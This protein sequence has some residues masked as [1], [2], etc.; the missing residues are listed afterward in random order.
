MGLKGE[1]PSGA[2]FHH[3]SQKEVCSAKTEEISFQAFTWLF[4]GTFCFGTIGNY[5]LINKFPS[6]SI[7]LSSRSNIISV[8]CSKSLIWFVPTIVWLSAASFAQHYTLVLK[9]CVT[10]HN[11]I[12]FYWLL[13]WWRDVIYLYWL[14]IWSNSFVCWAV[15]RDQWPDTKNRNHQCK[16]NPLPNFLIVITYLL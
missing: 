13:I 2:I 4:K 11:V 14:L 8:G 3:H 6:I 5:T 7:S 9:I 1:I 12:Y 10:Y 16:S 15:S